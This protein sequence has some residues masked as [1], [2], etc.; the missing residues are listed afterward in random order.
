M[1]SA[2]TGGVLS[3]PVFRDFMKQAL[4]DKPAV[5]F[6]VPPGIYFARIDARTGLRTSAPAGSGVILEAFK[7]GQQPP[8]SLSI[9][10]YSDA[11]GN[12]R[13]VSPEADRAVGSGTGGLY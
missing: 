13:T 12:K 10:G 2:A 8:D 3:A 11:F 9:I 6:R 5:P 4:A 1:G 7:Q